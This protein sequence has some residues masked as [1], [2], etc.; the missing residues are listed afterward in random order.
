MEDQPLSIE[1]VPS[2]LPPREAYRIMT[3]L[4]VPRP[5]AWVSTIG[6]DGSYNLAPFSFYNG[7]AGNP[8]TLMVSI[9]Q[10][11][12]RPKDTLRNIA[13]TGEFVVNVVS[14]SHI[15]AMNISAGEYDYEVDEFEL[16][17]VSMLGYGCSVAV[18]IG[19]PIP[20]L[21][22]EI[23][24]FTGVSDEEIFTQIIDYGEQ[25]PN[26]VSQSLGQV[27][28][29]ELRSGAITFRG[30]TV[31]TVPLSSVVKAREIAATLKDWIARGEF[32]LGEPQFTLPSA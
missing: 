12:G 31:P 28:Y 24:R 18:G 27:S 23:A 9:G 11:K 1:V 22:E 29:A 3:G 19:V 8:P 4:I 17:G 26:G 13:E 25:Y 5:I 15:E 7:V 21:S 20:V 10:R 2:T 16:A 14:C 6:A 30:E 32:L